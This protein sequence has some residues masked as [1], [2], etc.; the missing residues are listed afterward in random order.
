MSSPENGAIRFDEY[1]RLQVYIGKQWIT[2]HSLDTL[3]IF[4]RDENTFIIYHLT[5]R[6]K[7]AIAWLEDFKPKGEM[8]KNVIQTTI[9]F[10]E[11]NDAALFKLFWL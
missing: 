3:G 11:K 4:E 2:V 10:E 7:K 8:Y 9:S 5:D 6:G 1:A